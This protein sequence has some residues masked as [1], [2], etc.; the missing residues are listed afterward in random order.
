MNRIYYWNADLA[1]ACSNY[2]IA[3]AGSDSYDY[4]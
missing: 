2:A 3:M 1:S 4:R